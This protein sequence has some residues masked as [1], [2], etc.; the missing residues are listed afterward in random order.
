MKAAGKTKAEWGPEVTILLDLKKKLAETQANNNQNNS[1]TNPVTPNQ[2][3][4]TEME[5]KVKKQVSE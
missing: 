5:E 3:S 4:I 1:A 2:K